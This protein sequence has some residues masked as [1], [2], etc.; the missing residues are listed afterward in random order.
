V[1]SSALGALQPFLVTRHGLSLTQAGFLGGVLVFFSYLMQPAFGILA[2]R[3]HT[4]L[5]TVLGPLIAGLFISSMGAAGSYPWLLPMAAV[6]G[7]GMAMFHPQASVSAVAQVTQ[8]RGQ[9]MAV[10]ISSG[11]VGFALG[12]T[13]F[14]TL[15]QA[16]GLANL[17]IAF[18]PGVLVSLLLFRYFQLPER[19]ARRSPS[20]DWEALRPIRRPLT[21]LFLLVCIR[22]IV[23]VTFG[24]LLPLYLSRERGYGIIAANAIV[25]LYFAAGAFGGFIGGHMA[26]RFGGRRVIEFSMIGSVPFLAIFFLTGGH[27]A[28]AGLIAGGFILLFTIPVNVVM[29]QDLAPRQAGTISAIMMGFAWGVTGLIF[30]PLTGWI[31]DRS[32]MHAALG[33]LIVFPLLGFVLARLL[34]AHK[35]PEYAANPV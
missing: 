29:A 15:T 12:P 33:S 23:Q 26:D 21:L 18:L 1:Y 8:G 35:S 6:G 34:P 20:F 7:I 10:F 5:F 24:H 30:V 32:S 3:F 27:T 2:D 31:A 19:Q 11:A 9:S 25:S 16:V 22:S 13:I 17:W 4:K 28:I 14:A